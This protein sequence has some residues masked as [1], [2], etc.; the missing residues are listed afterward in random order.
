LRSKLVFCLLLALVPVLWGRAAIITLEMPV[1]AR[2]LGMGEAGVALTDDAYAPYYNPAGLAFGPL[3]DEWEHSYK[4]GD[5]SLQ[6][7]ALASRSR[8]GFLS[9]GEVWAGLPNGILFFDGREWKDYHREVLEGGTYIRDVLKRF[10][11]R[12]SDLDSLVDYVRAYNGVKSFEEEKLLVEVRVPWKLMIAEE[13][14]ALLYDTRLNRVWVGT[15]TGLLRFDGKGWKRYDVELGK[16]HITDLE[17][18]GATLWI[19]TT[20]GLFEYRRGEV[21]Q[22][23]NVLPGQYVTALA[24]SYLRKELYVGLQGHGLA[25]L[26]SKTSAPGAKGSGPQSQDQW[27]VYTLDDGLLSLQANQIAVD[28]A[29]HIWVAHQEGLS[30]FDLRKWEQVRFE[31]NAVHSVRVDPRGRLWIGTAKGVWKHEP[32]YI[33]AKGRKVENARRGEDEQEAL[34]TWTHFHT[35]NGLKNNSVTQIEPQG[36]DMWFSTAAGVE[37]LNLANRQVTLFYE[38]LLPVL[39]IPDLYHLF[40]GMTFPISDW[41]TIGAF[42]NFVSFGETVVG[43]ELESDLAA[44]VNSSEIVGGVGYGTRLTPDFALGVNFKFFFSDLSSGSSVGGEEAKTASYAVD[45]GILRKNLFVEG[46]DFGLA[47]ANMGPNVYYVDK[48]QEDPIPLT[49]RIGFTWHALRTADHRLI[50]VTDYSRESIYTDSDGDAAPFYISSW[51]SWAYPDGHENMESN[52][53]LVLHSLKKG[54]AGLG[55]EYVYSNTLALRMGYMHDNT[56]KRQEMNWGLGVLLSDVLQL[57]IAGIKEVG[58]LTEGV[59]EGQMRFSLLFKF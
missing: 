59:R 15:K 48:S 37:R 14:T 3:A 24:Y 31:N 35:G 4:L 9:Q 54:I 55:F 51:K 18:Q 25:K 36:Q 33:T 21:V 44:T 46:V 17:W 49:W 43:G 11:G 32:A 22:K 26:A 27:S 50:L 39:N 13:V 10:L 5:S 52:G 16:K 40:S 2:Q 34:G 58:N 28:S 56:G 23:G 20:D 29:G 53:E 8:S 7:T 1:G 45:L 42:V 30:H 19:G 12:E 38:K 6:I 41:G 47:L 57:D